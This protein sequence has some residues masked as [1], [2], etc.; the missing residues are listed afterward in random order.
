M[1]LITSHI[2]GA[3][4]LRFRSHLRI[5][6]DVPEEDWTDPRTGRRDP[7]VLRRIARE[8]DMCLGVYGSTVEPGTVG[9]GDEVV[10]VA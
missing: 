4:P 3:E 8:H 2:E 1:S 6:A 10:V 7:G 9:V 5:D